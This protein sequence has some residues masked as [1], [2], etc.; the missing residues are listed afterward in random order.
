MWF[1]LIFFVPPFFF[2]ARTPLRPAPALHRRGGRRGVAEERGDHSFGPRR[3]EAVHDL[4]RGLHALLRARRGAQVRLT[5]PRPS[6]AGLAHGPARPRHGRHIKTARKNACL[7]AARDDSHQRTGN[8]CV[9]AT[10]A[11]AA[12]AAAAAALLLCLLL[13]FFSFFRMAA[14]FLW[15]GM[16]STCELWR[17]KPWRKTVSVLV[18]GWESS[19]CAQ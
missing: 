15:F 9:T 4:R 13:L 2:L 17:R 12:A 6:V 16:G 14:D 1:S 18:F 10:T 3:A 19:C 7:P 8:C 11:A 5:S